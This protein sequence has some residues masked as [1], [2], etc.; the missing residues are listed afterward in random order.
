MRNPKAPHDKAL[1]ESVPRSGGAVAD[2]ISRDLTAR[3][4]MRAGLDEIAATLE[5]KASFQ[6]MG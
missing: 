3:T 4:M 5:E 1:A 2:E 6:V